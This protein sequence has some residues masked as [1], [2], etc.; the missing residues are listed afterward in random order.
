ME[1]QKMPT[2]EEYKAAHKRLKDLLHI[3]GTYD[4][5]DKEYDVV[6]EDAQKESQ[7]RIDAAWT[8]CDKKIKEHEHMTGVPKNNGDEIRRLQGVVEDYQMMDSMGKA[9]MVENGKFVSIGHRHSAE[10]MYLVDFYHGWWCIAICQSTIN[11]VTTRYAVIDRIAHYEFSE[12][13]VEMNKDDFR[14]ALQVTAPNLLPL[15]DGE[16]TI[17]ELEGAGVSKIL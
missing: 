8:E 11:G 12:K 7:A 16:T 10:M 3:R 1:E 4:S 6:R 15:M 2:N 13:F 14:V 17:K 9:F 5:F